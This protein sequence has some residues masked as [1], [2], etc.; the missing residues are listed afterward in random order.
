MWD[1]N[2]LWFSFVKLVMTFILYLSAL[3]FPW[4]RCLLRLFAY[5]KTDVC[6][7]F[8]FAYPVIFRICMAYSWFCAQGSFLVVLRDTSKLLEIKVGL[9]LCLASTLST[10][11]SPSLASLFVLFVSHYIVLNINPLSN[12]W[13]ATFSIIFQAA[14]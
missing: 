6:V 7:L 11:L 1:D 12:I 13:F 9:A 10:I 2:S 3:H 5:C 8:C 14:F 4:K